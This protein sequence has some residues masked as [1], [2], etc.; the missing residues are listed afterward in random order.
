MGA[1]PILGLHCVYL[2]R[3]SAQNV[4]KDE[5]GGAPAREHSWTSE[6]V[7]SRHRSDSDNHGGQTVRVHPRVDRGRSIVGNGLEEGA[8]HEVKKQR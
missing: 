7:R 5:G 1:T 3:R 4:G 8:A 2:W 6:V